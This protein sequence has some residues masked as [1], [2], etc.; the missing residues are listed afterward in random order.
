MIDAFVGERHPVV[1]AAADFE[2]LGAAP[3]IGI[4]FE[5]LDQFARGLVNGAVLARSREHFDEVLVGQR[6]LARQG[7]LQGLRDRRQCRPA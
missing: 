6:S 7:R 5:C 2:F 1:H 3:E 4:R